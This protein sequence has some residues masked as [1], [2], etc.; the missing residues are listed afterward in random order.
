MNADAVIAESERSDDFEA[1]TGPHL[2]TTRSR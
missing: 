2:L 1:R